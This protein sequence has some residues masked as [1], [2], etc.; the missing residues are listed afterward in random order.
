MAT[1][2]TP[3]PTD[4]PPFPC[5]H[6]GREFDT[7]TSRGAHYRWCEKRP[8]YR[9]PAKKKRAYTQS[10]ATRRQRRTA[11]LK[12]GERSDRPFAAAACTDGACKHPD[13][14]PCEFRESVVEQGADNA[15]CW[16][17]A[18]GLSADRPT[19]LDE[20]QATYEKGLD[21]PIVLDGLK[22][23]FFALQAEAFLDASETAL[24]DGLIQRSQVLL[25][26]TPDGEQVIGERLSQHPGARLAF[27]QLA[28]NLGATAADER[29]TRKAYGG[30]LG[31]QTEDGFDLA[32]DSRRKITQ[33]KNTGDS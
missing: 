30:A 11:A 14:R 3:K 32:V 13:G 26:E 31:K 25:F 33:P 9:P 23:R 10:P 16:P 27:G 21:D 19:R 22:A 28:K 1:K 18:L 4:G 15:V 7:R 17:D 20:L 24:S 2:R 5:E 29:T 12:H 6:C 8:G